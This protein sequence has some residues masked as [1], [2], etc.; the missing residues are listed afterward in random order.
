ML[1]ELQLSVVQAVKYG[2]YFAESAYLYFDIPHSSVIIQI[3]DK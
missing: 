3:F 2:V 1:T